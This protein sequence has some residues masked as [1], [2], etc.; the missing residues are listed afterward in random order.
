MTD[1]NAATYDY[2]F[3]ALAKEPDLTVSQNHPQPGFYRMKQGQPVAIWED[4]EGIMIMVGADRMVAPDDYE[5]IW[6]RC[7]SRPVTQEA[8]DAVIDGGVWPD[9]DDVIRETLGD[10]IRDANDPEA[11][12]VL[13]DMLKAAAK[14]Y[15]TISD[16]D[17]AAKA[18]TIRTRTLELKGKADKLREA[19]K[20]PHLDAG[21][22]VDAMWQPLIKSAD[23]V[24][25]QLRQ[26][27]ERFETVKLAARR[28]KEQEEFDARMKAA[29]DHGGS[30]DM[31]G[32]DQPEPVIQPK[33]GIKGGYGRAASVGAKQVVTGISDLTLLF[34]YLS[35]VGELTD[36]MLKLAQR[37]VDDGQN[38]P[39]VTVEERAIVR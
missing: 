32:P 22:K 17:T 5:D 14:N 4:S 20:K 11:I 26:A 27:M 3:S 8:Y 13:I 24:V 7:C 2:W 9:V 21:K 36:L 12:N 10:N 23:A 1:L 35:G 29:A 15:E 38:V 28:K 18:Q 39:G 30:V 33:P 19:A 16:D 31:S 6:T 34:N 25:S 37:Y